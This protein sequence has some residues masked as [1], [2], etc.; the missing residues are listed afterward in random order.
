LASARHFVV[1]LVVIVAVLNLE[2]LHDLVV[3]SFDILGKG[4]QEETLLV[5]IVFVRSI[6]A[7]ALL[8]NGS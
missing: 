1:K 5:I 7:L 3:E 6:V 2:A 8:G 4:L